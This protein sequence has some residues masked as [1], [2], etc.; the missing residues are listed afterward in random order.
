[1]YNRQFRSLA[2]LLG[3]EA[4]EFDELRHKIEGLILQEM[5]TVDPVISQRIQNLERE[6]TKRNMAAE[7]GRST[8][9]LPSSNDYLRGL[10][11]ELGRK[12]KMI[13]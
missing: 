1:M 4:M 8:Q 11:N 6:L 5:S 3:N 9:S 7:V 10:E 2:K 12:S 13:S